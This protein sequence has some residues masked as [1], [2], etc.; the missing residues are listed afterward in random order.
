MGLCVCV[1]VR[2][3][4]DVAH[5]G[6]FLWGLPSGRKFLREPPEGAKRAKHRAEGEARKV[7]T[8]SEAKG[9]AQII[10][11]LTKSISRKGILCKVCNGLTSAAFRL[12]TPCPFSFVHLLNRF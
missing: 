6:L 2:C 7:A 8:R 4:E 5:M 12:L 9:H 3:Y 10:K 11:Y 1:V